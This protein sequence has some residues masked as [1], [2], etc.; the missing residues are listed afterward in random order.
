MG[1]TIEAMVEHYKHLVETPEMSDD[2]RC[3]VVKRRRELWWDILKRIKKS[4]NFT[5]AIQMRVYRA[6]HPEKAMEQ[7]LC[8]RAKHQR[9]KK[10]VLTYYGNG[11]LACIKCGEGKLVCLT[12][13]HKNGRGGRHRKFA[14]RSAASFYKWLETENYPKGYQTLCMNCQFVKREENNEQGKYADEP[15]DWQN[16]LD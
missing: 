1:E 5:K 12:I 14:L 11:T 6:A 3:F 8:Q 4:P 2:E 15:I 16:I 9:L 13:D 7:W 10:R